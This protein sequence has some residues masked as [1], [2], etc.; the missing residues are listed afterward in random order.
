MASNCSRVRPSAGEEK[1]ER[2]KVSI[3]RLSRVEKMEKRGKDERVSTQQ[4]YL[5]GEKKGNEGQPRSEE[6]VW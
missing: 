3:S 1:E 6:E 2:E 4:R 5:F